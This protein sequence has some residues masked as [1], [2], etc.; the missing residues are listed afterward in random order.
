[1]FFAIPETPTENDE[2][3]MTTRLYEVVGVLWA[4][5]ATPSSTKILRNTPKTNV[6]TES[7]LVGLQDEG[8][9]DRIRKSRWHDHRMDVAE[10]PPSLD[11]AGVDED[12]D[13]EMEVEAE[14]DDGIIE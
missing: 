2:K 12:T 10:A 7:R 14:D 11:V 13:V 3:N 8:Y 4:P 9:L 5:L 6:Q 1:M